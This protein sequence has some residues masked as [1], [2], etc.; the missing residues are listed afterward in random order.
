MCG[1]CGMFL[2]DRLRRVDPGVLREMN[3]QIVHRG[4]D[5][6]GFLVEENVGLAMRRLSIIDVKTGHQP[7]SNEDETI[8]L[9]FNGEIYNYKEL[10]DRLLERG[11]RFRT[12]SDTETIV[13]LYEDFGRDCVLQLRGMFAFAL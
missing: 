8:W 1:I 9:V 10:R 2:T 13:H 3:Q 7:V 5:D 6:D 12:H 4:P 11:H